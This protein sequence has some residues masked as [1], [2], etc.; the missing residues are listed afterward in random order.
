MVRRPDRSSAPGLHRK[1]RMAGKSKKH[2]VDNPVPL[3]TD[4][5]PQMVSL[6]V[7]KQKKTSRGK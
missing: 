2:R 4:K 1:D 7:K 6:K 5:K 3:G